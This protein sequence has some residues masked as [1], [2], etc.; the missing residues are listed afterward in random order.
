MGSRP[1]FAYPKITVVGIDISQRMVDYARIQAQVQGLDNASFRVMDVTKPLEFSDN[2][3][4]LV[5]ARFL[6]F[7]PKAAWPKL[8]QECLRITRPAG[9][10]RLT[11]S[12]WGFTNSPAYEKLYA[13]F[14]SAMRKAGQSFSP[15][16]D[17]L[18][19]T[20]ML[21]GFL[22]SAGCINIEQK[23]HVIDFSVDTQD[24]N[25]FRQNWIV[26]FKLLQP[27]CIKMGT[28]TQAELDQLYQQ[29]LLEMLEDNFR[30]I[31]FLLTAWGKKP[32]EGPQ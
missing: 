8:I 32:L 29:M 13:M 27:F 1:T 3:F 6:G 18:G 26:A 31:M 16:R 21:G 24:Y 9:V 14:A 12:E 10:I 11:E 23:A 19:I 28:A 7:L 17:H 25:A 4:D 5:N 2:S 15:E 20:P 22:R 30:G